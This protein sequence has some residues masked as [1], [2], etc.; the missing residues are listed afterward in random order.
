MIKI[1]R[2]YFGNYVADAAQLLAHGYLTLRLPKPVINISNGNQGFGSIKGTTKKLGTNYSPV[3][4]CVFRRDNRLLLWETKSKPNG[5]YSFRNI[6]VGLEC[7]I[8]AFDPNGIYNALIQ[9]KVVA[10]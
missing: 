8:V 7:F 4:V 10:K 9:D 3:P 6:A 1:P 2:V 5:S